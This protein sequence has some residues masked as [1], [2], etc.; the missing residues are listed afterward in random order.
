M[1]KITEAHSDSLFY[2]D[3]QSAARDV[4]RAAG[5]TKAV[6]ALLWPAKPITAAQQRLTDCLNPQRDEKLSPD[7]FLM[8]LRIGREHRCHAL[9]GHIAQETAYTIPTPIDPEDEKARLQRQFIERVAALTA[10][11]GRLQGDARG[12]PLATGVDVP[13]FLRRAP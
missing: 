2:E 13:D 10:I 7:E 6:A 8:L 4:I 5:G 11:A 9:I 1:T 12:A 3:W